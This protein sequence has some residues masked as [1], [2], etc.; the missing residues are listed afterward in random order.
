MCLSVFKSPST[1]PLLFLTSSPFPPSLPPSLPAQVGGPVGAIAGA[2]VG[3]FA[4][5]V[6][7]STGKSLL[8][9]WA[10]L[11]AE[12]R[13][14]IL[15]SMNTVEQDDQ[16]RAAGAGAAAGGAAVGA[17]A[18]GAAAAAGGAEG[19]SSLTRAQIQALRDQLPSSGEPECKVCMEK[20]VK[21]SLHPCGHA[22]LC[23]S[24]YLGLGANPSCPM[25]RAPARR[26]TAIFF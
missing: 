9:N 11:P 15:D 7:A 24:C 3:F 1:I 8:D 6:R 16:R 25:C 21:L 2:A 26:V 5:V 14:A 19:P 20:V 18:A 23:A 10:D 13:R 4:G 22:C 17:S 12:Q